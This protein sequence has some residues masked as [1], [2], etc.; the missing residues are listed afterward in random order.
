MY[1]IYFQTIEKTH[2]CLFENGE[3]KTLLNLP[4]NDKYHSF[5]L[6]K[7]YEATDEGLIKFKKDFDNWCYELLHNDILDIE[8]TKYFNHRSAVE[9]TF[10]TLC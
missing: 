2:R 5:E 9:L 1:I 8:Y 3:I 4:P 7:G 6:F 10:Q